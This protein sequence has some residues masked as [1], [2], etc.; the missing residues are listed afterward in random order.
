MLA[1]Y[2]ENAKNDDRTINWYQQEWQ[3]PMLAL[4]TEKAK[5][6]HWTINCYTQKLQ[7]P[8]LTLVSVIL[9]LNN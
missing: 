6:D 3:R 9:V 2:T 8:M 1:L 7:R 5:N 4:Y